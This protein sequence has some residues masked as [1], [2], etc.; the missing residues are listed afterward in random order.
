MESGSFILIIIFSVS[1][2]CFSFSW[3]GFLYV[4]IKVAFGSLRLDLFLIKSMW[5]L[6]TPDFMILVSVL[7]Q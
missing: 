2:M 1:V 3:V 4:F 6:N 5:V 7:I